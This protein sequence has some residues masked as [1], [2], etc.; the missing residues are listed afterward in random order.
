MSVSATPHV[1]LFDTHCHLTDAQ[2]A[3]DGEAV[4]AA[5]RA[6]GIVGFLAVPT[7]A[8]SS[9][10]V[11][12]LAEREPDIWAAVGIHPN[13]ADR[14]T[15]SAREQVAALAGHPRVAA[16]GE[17]GLDFYR[18]RVPP[19]AQLAALRWQIELAQRFSKPL[20]I[21]NR[22]ADEVL[23]AELRRAYAGA[24][25]DARTGVLHC[26]STTAE[27]ARTLIDVGFYVA[28]G[29]NLTY[30][31]AES[32]RGVA[33]VLP[34]D[35]LLL[36][37]DAPY[38]APEPWRGRRNQPANISATAATLAAAHGLSLHDLA[39]LT[40]ANARR[41]LRL[42]AWTPHDEPPVITGEDAGTERQPQRQPG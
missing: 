1:S 42:D 12:A 16:I 31:R 33:A 25:R 32:L 9:A 22:E 26:F 13:S 27:V 29:G 6:A 4:R 11:L 20:V 34:T 7:D 17:S 39:A 38:L 8:A 10:D 41:L 24:G 36:E 18:D 14:A 5:A 37:T 23:V 3:E 28:F 35:R 40:T 19:E 30:R 21:H 2:F 15:A